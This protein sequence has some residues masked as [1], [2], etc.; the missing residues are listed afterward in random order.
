MTPKAIW[1]AL[2]KLGV[3]YKKAMRHPKADADA[4]RGFREKIKRYERDGRPIVYIDE[5]GF[6][7]DMPRTQGAP[8][9]WHT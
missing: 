9:C 8:L 7:T 3:T 4:Q 1:Q 2:R 6:A 5:S